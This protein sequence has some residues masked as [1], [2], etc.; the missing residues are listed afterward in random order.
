MFIEKK[1]KGVAQR[2]F[3]SNGNAN[4]VITVSDPTDLF[5]KQEIILKSNTQAPQA[6]EIKRF[7]TNNSFYVGPKGPISARSNL[8][9]YTVADAASFS[10]PEQDRPGIKPEEINRATY[11]EE[12]ITAVRTFSVDEN[13]NPYTLQ[14][15]LPVRIDGDINI[16]N[17]NINV[18]LSHIEGPN[19]IPAD[20][21]RL[22]DGVNEA[23]ITPAKVG[24]LTGLNT[25]SI[26]DLFTKPFTKLTVL[27]KNDDG[28]PLTI[29]SAYQGVNV[30]LMTIL[31]DSDGDFQDADVSDL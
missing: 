24:S 20:S 21:I 6:V 13:G 25:N 28:D 19:N 3:T 2:L 8:S 5:V 17:A 27:T 4:G 9:L 7:I 10:A 12:P 31:Y 15:P 23:K 11:M 22:G 30:Q 1:R 29:R 18:K 26:N 14:N 16:E